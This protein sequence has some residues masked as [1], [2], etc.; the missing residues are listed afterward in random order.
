MKTDVFVYIV[1]YNQ[2][3]MTIDC[4]KSILNSN[5]KDFHLTIIDNGS[6]E[7]NYK[8]LNKIQSEKVTILRSEVNLGYAKGVNLGLKS[9]RDIIPE[10]ILIMNNDTNIDKDSIKNLVLCCQRHNN[11]AIVSGKVYHYN[12]PN[13]IQYIGSNFSNKILLKEVYPGKDEEDRG[14]FEIE[15]ERDMLDDI[16]WL[17][18]YNILFDV[19]Y[20]CEYFFMYSEQ[21][22]FA[23]RAKRKGYK[24]IYT[25]TAR[26]WHIGSLSS[27]QGERFSLPVCYWRSK[28][29]LIYLYRN[30]NFL[31]FIYILGKN[32][33]K[34]VF[35]SIFSKVEQR[36]KNFSFL[37]GYCSG[38]LWLIFRNKITNYNPYIR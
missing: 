23:L 20:Y 26:I 24:L 22:D 4:T 10:Y 35:K 36:N 2:P 8:I 25:P 6:T 13:K 34:F 33:T 11:K 19:G 7:E 21:A 12:N 38:I 31:V 5:Y 37:R 3:E 9:I 32:L 15:K 27:G 18:P 28:S 16:F 1:N 29:S 30:L 14:Q 17:L